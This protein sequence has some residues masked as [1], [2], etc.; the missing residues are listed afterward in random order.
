[1]NKGGIV[2]YERFIRFSMIICLWIVVN[3]FVIR[4]VEVAI[5]V[6]RSMLPLALPSDANLRSAGQLDYIF[7][8]LLQYIIGIVI[9][10][11]PCIYAATYT[12]IKLN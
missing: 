6:R 5:K 8:N 9:C 12:W 1:M 2:V 7:L 3:N 4:G 10:F 11:K